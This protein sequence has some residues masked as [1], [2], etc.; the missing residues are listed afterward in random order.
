MGILD[1]AIREHLELKRSHGANEDELRQKE[2]EAFGPVRQDAAPIEAEAVPPP[3]PGVVDEQT[4][5]LTPSEPFEL[6]PL[7]PAPEDPYA[8]HPGDHAV[9]DPGEA[10]QHHY[11]PPVEEPPPAEHV[12]PAA[13]AGAGM[14]EPHRVE[15]GPPTPPEHHH[16]EQHPALH[17]TGEFGRELHAPEPVFGHG[18]EAP[19]APT[20]EPVIPEP[21]APLQPAPEDPYVGDPPSGHP[22]TEE[23]PPRQS[24][25]DAADHEVGPIEGPNEDVLEETPE[26]LQDAPEH[27]RLWFEQ[28]PP[29]DFDFGE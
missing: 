9:P 15:P 8:V 20:E 29:R 11:A 21:D 2:A 3:E 24:A 23:P 13:E 10:G 18:T 22:G 17:D 16:D 1:D 27:D 4:Q 6:E 14:L 12:S 25:E 26:F 5:L 28:K 19:P 7:E